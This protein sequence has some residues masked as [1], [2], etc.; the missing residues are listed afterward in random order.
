MDALSPIEATLLAYLRA[1]RGRIVSRDELL[2]EVWGYAPTVRSRTVEV[3]VQR[4]RSK[5]EHDPRQ[6]TRLLTVRGK[7]YRWVDDAP[8]AEVDAPPGRAAL[9]RAARAA[10]DAGARVV[11]LL[12]TV[13][14]GKTT[15][16]RH[17]AA[18]APVVEPPELPVGTR[19]VDHPEDHLDR[20]RAWLTDADAPVVVASRVRLDVAGEVVLPVAPL[21]AEDAAAAYAVLSTTLRPMA[22][23][24][25]E[26]DAAEGHAFLLRLALDLPE[27]LPLDALYRPDPPPGPVSVP[28]RHRSVDAAVERLLADDAALAELLS[29]LGSLPP[30][31]PTSL[32]EARERTLLQRH[33]LPGDGALPRFVHA[34]LTRDGPTRQARQRL[35]AWG[36][37]RWASDGTQAL[38][39]HADAFRAAAL[40]ATEPERRDLTLLAVVANGDRDP[41]RNLALLDRHTTDTAWD[42]ELEIHRVF[43]LL[44]SGDVAAAQV[45][46]ARVEAR[47]RPPTVLLAQAALGVRVFAADYAGA[48]AYMRASGLLDAPHPPS[49]RLGLVWKTYGS[50]LMRL[51]EPE[52]ARAAF[53]TGRSRSRGRGYTAC[54]YSLASFELLAGR[55]ELAARYLD[56]LASLELPPLLACG[57][58]SQ[59]GTLAA[60]LGDDPTAESASARALAMPAA[61]AWAGEIHL[62]R[63]RVLCALGKPEAALELLLLLAH[64]DGRAPLR[65]S[66][67]LWTALCWRSLGL[68]RR[69]DLEA[70]DLP[71]VLAAAYAAVRDGRPVDP[72]D[73]CAPEHIEHGADLQLADRLRRS[74]GA[75][76]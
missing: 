65:A 33:G 10:L 49:A 9:V 20:V 25:R 68:Q 73:P 19:F 34:V 22:S 17:L 43:L 6:P 69:A 60:L 58:A 40:A 72:V 37:P 35:A 30:P 61:S 1:A 47:V 36:M 26:L 41:R 63:A 28:P 18:T 16:L 50:A 31:V 7:G 15:V 67:R 52:E 5:V 54:T 44:S 53:I 76:A 38:S 46:A 56:E 11:T 2:T 39:D 8:T 3:T 57:A 14:A 59:R 24:D 13:G 4:L 64:Q 66:V 62:A 74:D 51:S 75:P 42:D 71:V 70:A 21:P 32:L 27:D 48:R 23:T 55:L 29:W 12:G 45:A